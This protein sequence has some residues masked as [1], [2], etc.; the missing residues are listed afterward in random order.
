MQ[1]EPLFIIKIGGHVIDDGSQLASFVKE[2]A[3]L[4]QK[5]ILV[6]G[7]GKIATAIGE[8]LHIRSVYSDGRRITDDDTLSL[9]TMVYGGL[10]NKG[11]VASLQAHGCNAIGLTGADGNMIP[12]VKRPVKETDYGWA[13]DV[14]SEKIPGASWKMLMDNGLV[15]VV[16]PL[17]HDQK[18]HMLNTNAD[19]IASVLAIA[20][21]SLYETHLI[22]CFEK[23]GV[24]E[25]VNNEETVIKHIT[26]Q[27]YALLKKEGRLF[28]GI[29]PK[30]DNAF[31]AIRKGVQQVIIGDARH[32]AALISG[33]SGTNISL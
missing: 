2:F 9:V 18:G 26:P 17:T 5:K 10:V 11:I 33:D 32:L 25:D 8:K 27:Q 21:S 16:A 30:I 4:P 24:L 14:A 1:R 19:T 7:G 13:G 20:L 22:F 31:D 15:P 6:H 29:L 3:A 23:K 12:A 28:A